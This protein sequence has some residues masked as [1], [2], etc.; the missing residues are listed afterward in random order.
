M[1]PIFVF[2][3]MLFAA[4]LVSDLAGRSVVSTASLFLLAGFAASALGLFH[5]DSRS[6]VIALGAEAAVVATLFLDGMKTSARELRDTWRLPGRA[7]LFALPL[8]LLGT[9]A[10][11]HVIVGLP[12]TTAALVGAVL[13]PTDPVFSAALIGSDHVPVSLRRLLN[14]ESGLNDGLMAPVVMVLIGLSGGAETTVADAS[15]GVALGLGIGAAV[16]LAAVW[17][18]RRTESRAA[19]TYRPLF[20]VALVVIA[21][22][23]AALAHANVFLAAFIAGVVLATVSD[24]AKEHYEPVGEAAAELLKLGALLVFGASLSLHLFVAEGWRGL[25]FA[26]A[27]LVVPRPL[28]IGV[29]MLRSRLDWHETFAAGWFGPKGFASVLFG[30]LVLHSGVPDRERA[31]HLIATV[32]VG[33]MLAHST[34]DSLVARWFERRATLRGEAA[35][36]RAADDEGDAL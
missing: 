10:L 31:F 1:L 8:T 18:Y 16:V 12:W 32:I 7:L 20:A 5:V 17:L 9:A 2:G 15:L 14:A 21:A 28:A 22:S 29:A 13:T 3:V 4:V 36:R 23:G 11:A 35:P 33:S 24:K 25:A 30:L 19:P 27:A 6:H 26:V 34:T